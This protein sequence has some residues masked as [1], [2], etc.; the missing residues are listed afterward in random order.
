MP[1][2]SFFSYTN[3][4]LIYRLPFAANDTRL[5][6]IIFSKEKNYIFFFKK[7][8]QKKKHQVKINEQILEHCYS[9]G[10]NKLTIQIPE[11]IQ[12]AMENIQIL[13]RNFRIW[14]FARLLKNGLLYVANAHKDNL[15]T[16]SS[17]VKYLYNNKFKLGIIHCFVKVHNCDCE[18]Q[19]C[20]CEHLYFAILE[21]ELIFCNVFQTEGNYFQQ[22]RLSFLQ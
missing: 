13:L 7:C 14:T 11:S 2:I 15:Q 10:V 9:V 21:N 16:C 18:I 19:N 4:S 22:H 8:C 12:R 3:S 20:K 17:A 6:R 1:A 5:F